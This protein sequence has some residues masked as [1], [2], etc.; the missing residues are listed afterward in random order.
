MQAI[1]KRILAVL[2]C[3]ALAFAALPVSSAAASGMDAFT[4]PD[5]LPQ[6]PFEDVVEGKWFYTAVQVQ[7]A[8]GLMSGTSETEFSPSG[9]VS[10][11]QAVAVT[12]R[13]YEAYHGIDPE[14]TPAP[15][16]TEPSESTEPVE[17]V[18]PSE[19]TEPTEPVE[20]SETTEPAEPAEPTE[21]TEASEP[22]EPSESTE[23][24]E[25]L[26]PT[27]PTEPV[28]P[29]EPH[30]PWYI[31][32]GKRA[33]EYG[34]LPDTL[35]NVD[36]SRPATRAEVAELLFR[37]LP[38]A[39]LTAINM[40]SS[41]PDYVDFAPYWN[42][43]ITLYQAGI[44]SGQDKYGTFCPE[45]SIRRS[46][47]A[48]MLTRLVCSE[49][50]VKK[51]F[52]PAPTGMK[53]FSV[54]SN[55]QN[56]Y[57]DVPANSWYAKFVKIQYALGLMSGTGK[58]KFSPDG[59]ATVAQ[60]TAVAVRVY[61]RYHAI[62]NGSAYYGGQHWYDYAMARGAQYGL[63]P[64]TLQQSPNRAAT[65]A[66]VAEILY[67][68]L[69]KSEFTAINTV[70]S[71]P[72]YVDFAPYWNSVIT[73]Y[74]AGIL[75]GQD[76]YGTFCPEN[77]IRRSELASMLTRLV[78]PERREKKTF[79]PAPTG[80]KVFSV[81]SNLQNPYTDVPANSW[82]A[83]FVK[84]QYAL[85][86]MSGTGKNKF[87]PD[88]T[89]TVAQITAVAVRVYERYHAIPNGSAYYGGQHWY[90]YA[91]TRGTQY[92]LLPKS[93]QQSPNRAATRAEVAEIL[94]RSLPKSE[95]TAINTVS[96]LPDYTAG[97]PYYSSV[98]AL[99][100]AGILS[101]SD[102][103]GTF[104]AKQ[105][106]HRAELA[107]MLTRLVCPQYRHT[108][109]LQKKPYYETITY[110][111]SGAGRKLTAYR[112]GD[113]KNV[114]VLTFAIHGWEDNFDRDGQLLVDT[115]NQLMNTLRT[116]YNTLIASGDWSVYVL[117][118]LNPDGLYDGWTCNGPGRCTT[119]YLTISGGDVTGKGIDMNRCFPYKFTPRSDSR[120]F[121]GTQPL[122]AKEAQ[123]LAKFTRSVKGS[124]KNVLIDT[125]GWY[126]QTIVSS[127]QSSKIY[128]AFRA[129]FPATR[130]TSLS[131]GSGY[132]SSWAGY[133][134]G[135]DACLF[136][137]PNVT[138]KRDFQN[139]GYADSFI[140]AISQLLKSY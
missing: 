19:S 105:N 95:F 117:P 78:C 120:N 83:K 12:V 70:S 15:E 11:W 41:L 76:K 132:Y 134:L 108:F 67:R 8:L 101:G 73:L 33:A 130:Y 54:P 90:D 10:L 71:L 96:G 22:A 124:A 98:I 55:L 13:V 118:T 29:P 136:E 38:T 48:S 37:S 86:L 100:R 74:R 65:R 103:Y 17:P 49:Q 135:Y 85:G 50:R 104:N 16:P 109:V 69:P 110:G 51:A 93:L 99:Y 111:T 133:E 24:T 102:P 26:E 6:L 18:E 89:A 92:G 121:N 127:G 20:P 42:S 113:G 39:E 36:L 63:L 123:A 53:V 45:N 27:E 84:I 77:S 137:F 60:I 106:I 3:V 112:F 52:S 128:Q 2:L 31:T 46:E 28:D 23:P 32:Y 75:S 94:Y 114:M 30:E 138:G 72:D 119:H 80:M 62:P 56:P 131:G 126:N 47:L 43:V 7:Y 97:D 81:P 140:R 14:P 122:Q 58:N 9:T 25:P 40:V 61:E 5:E 57:T 44:L 4:L 125:H 79:S 68:C 91:M 139:H 34:L 107:S 115:A 64:Q 87:S 35:E 129:C 21:P 88:G 59:T 116:N 1:K 66:E 82:Y